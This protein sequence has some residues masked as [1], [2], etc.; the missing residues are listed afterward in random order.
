[1][2]I[3]VAPA[4]IGKVT[5]AVR[6][7]LG[8]GFSSLSPCSRQSD[9]KVGVSVCSR[10]GPAGRAINGLIIDII[11]VG[12]HSCSCLIILAPFL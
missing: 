7:S 1:M 4:P 3:G 2:E 12:I 6:A 8:A 10:G 5:G 9:K 11:I